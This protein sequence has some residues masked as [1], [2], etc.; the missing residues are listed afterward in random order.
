MRKRGY[1]LGPLLTDGLL[2]HEPERWNDQRSFYYE[3]IK[4]GLVLSY[5]SLRIDIRRR[6]TWLF[7]SESVYWID[8][9]GLHRQVLAGDSVW[10]LQDQAQS[11]SVRLLLS[12]RPLLSVKPASFCEASLIM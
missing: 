5:W 10:L 7:V 1:L 3:R 2:F 8:R 4:F 12:V 11:L 9:L 6:E